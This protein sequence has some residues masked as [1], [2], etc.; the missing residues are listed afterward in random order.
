MWSLLMFWSDLIG[1]IHYKQ[2][3]KKW[4][5]YKI[6]PRGQEVKRSRV[7]TY[8]SKNPEFNKLSGHASVSDPL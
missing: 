3:N 6:T 4:A 7:T 1:P 5:T 8:Y 2:L